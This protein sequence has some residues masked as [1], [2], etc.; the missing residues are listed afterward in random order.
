MECLR[1]RSIALSRLRGHVPSRAMKRALPF[2]ARPYDRLEHN[3]P[4]IM[5]IQRPGRTRQFL[6]IPLPCFVLFFFAFVSLI[7]LTAG[8]PFAS[9]CPLFL[10]YICV[11]GCASIAVISRY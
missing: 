8:P 6:W 10:S 7:A 4:F 2:G 1:I 9:A 5:R 3:A 11:W